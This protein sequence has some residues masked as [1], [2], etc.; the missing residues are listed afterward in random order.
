LRLSSLVLFGFAAALLSAPKAAARVFDFK[1]ERFAVSFGGTFGPSTVGTSAYSASSGN[2][3]VFDGKG[4]LSNS[5][6]EVGVLFNG[7]N[8]NL[9]LSAEYL[10]ARDQVGL[11]GRDSGGT[12]LFNLNSKVNALVPVASLEFIVAKVGS[13]RGLLGLSWGYAFV[14]LDNDYTMTSSGQSTLGKGSFKESGS[15]KAPLAQIYTG[16]EFLLT[17]TVTTTFSAGYRYVP[18]SSFK[19]TKE[20]DAISGQQHDSED[21]KNMDGSVRSFDMSGAWVGLTFR[22]Y[23]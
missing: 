19:S 15:A 9:R 11:E 6:G 7:Q 13:S 18:V 12:L 3:V 22:F 16:W 4:A 20:T 1:S 10:W 14:N 2:G 23:L 8:M 5:S 21:I 17:D